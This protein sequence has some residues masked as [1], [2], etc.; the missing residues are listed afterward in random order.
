MVEAFT[1]YE[2]LVLLSSKGKNGNKYL[3]FTLSPLKFSSFLLQ[4]YKHL[5][6]IAEKL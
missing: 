3:F 6:L 4:N 2:S 1:L 5:F